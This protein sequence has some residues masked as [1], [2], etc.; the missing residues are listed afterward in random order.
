M[1]SDFGGEPESKSVGFTD[2]LNKYLAF[3]L[4]WLLRG[5]LSNN[6][7]GCSGICDYNGTFIPFVSWSRVGLWTSRENQRNL[8]ATILWMEKILH[9]LVD[10]SHYF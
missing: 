9:Q 7:W 2:L 5:F 10:L 6:I 1:L 8:S 4:L 3:W